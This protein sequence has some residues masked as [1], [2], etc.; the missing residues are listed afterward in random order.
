M[1]TVK[2]I[3]DFLNS[4]A[5]FDTQDEWDN[6]GF[7][8][9]EFRKEVK[10]AVLSLDPTP[11][12]VEFAKSVNA[13]LLLTHHPVIF[14]P[15]ESVTE[16]SPA[17]ELARA[18]ISQISTHTCFDKAENGINDNLAKALRLENPERLDGGNVVV[19]EL[20]LE[21]SV[22]DLA[23]YVSLMLE[24]DKVTFTNTD[25]PIKKVAVGGGG[26]GVFIDLAMENADCFVIGEMKY[27]EML[28]AQQQG[29]AVICAGHYESENEPFLMLK[30]TLEK[31]FPDVE[32]LTF[33]QKDSII[34]IGR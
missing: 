30:D 31:M 22:D 18:G 21:M 24:S 6:S 25:K 13:D 23:D 34:G 14:S 12:A 29:R 17:Y 11:S 20:S 1:T 26:S 3:Y 27:H 10:T 5:P 8:V 7:L 9:G 19:G 2:N 32:F 28:D 33:E 4:I 16:G 15:L